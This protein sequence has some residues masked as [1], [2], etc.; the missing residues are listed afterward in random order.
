MD[1]W[2]GKAFVLLGLTGP[3]MLLVPAPF[4]KFHDF[5]AG[6]KEGGVR[7]LV[8]RFMN[9]VE[10]PGKLSWLV[11]ENVVL[12]RYLWTLSAAA[13]ARGMTVFELLGKLDAGRLTAFAMFAGHYIHRATIYPLLTM[14][15][16]SPSR[17][18]VF[19]LASGWQFLNGYLQAIAL[20]RATVLTSA[21]PGSLQYTIG[22]LVFLIGMIGNI[23]H[24]NAL[25]QIRRKVAKPTKS[26]KP[27]EVARKYEVP[28]GGLFSLVAFPHYLL[29]W[30]EWT[31]YAL[32]LGQP[33]GWWI[34]PLEIAVMLPRAVGGLRWYREKFDKKEIPPR[35]KAV[36]PW[37]I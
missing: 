1:T 26:E 10:I 8:Y 12:V 34:V 25:A 5:Y 37:L 36:I 13:E 20:L 16:M 7:G 19:A 27:V 6:N 2:Q 33:E 30:I 28:K 17:P 4:G 14:P 15:S 22:V 18:A 24:D 11:S 29:E 9:G 3:L 35:W 31:G 21:Q 32:V 23:W